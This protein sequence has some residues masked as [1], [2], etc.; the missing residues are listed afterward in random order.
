MAKNNKIVTTTV[1]FEIPLNIDI[2][3]HQIH[4]KRI[5]ILFPFSLPA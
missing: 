4:Q 1:F 2:D 5:N 3:D